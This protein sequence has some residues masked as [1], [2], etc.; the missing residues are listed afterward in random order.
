MWMKHS[1]DSDELA[2]AWRRTA[3]VILRASAFGSLGAR[4]LAGLETRYSSLSVRAN[5]KKICPEAAMA[6]NI[7]SAH[8]SFLKPWWEQNTT[9]SPARH[10]KASV[11]STISVKGMQPLPPLAVLVLQYMCKSCRAF[12]P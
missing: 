4:P 11:G 7:R 10:T 6:L 12:L 2:P 9:E 8:S 5:L 3:P 1:Q